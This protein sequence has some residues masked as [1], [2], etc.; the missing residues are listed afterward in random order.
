MVAVA[1]QIKT[2]GKLQ[3]R[4]AKALQGARDFVLKNIR[5][6]FPLNTDSFEIAQKQAGN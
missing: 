2:K 5:G 3:T 1:G 4:M 6:R